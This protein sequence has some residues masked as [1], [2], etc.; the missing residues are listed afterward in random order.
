MN[1][2]IIDYIVG[3]V[4]NFQ[5]AFMLLPFFT[6]LIYHEREFSSF[7]IA[8]AVCLVIGIPLT[9]KKPKNKVFYTKDGCVAVALSWVAL[10]VFGALPFVVS[11]YIPHPVDA[12][13]ET[14]SGFTTTGSSILTD[15]EVLPH[16]VL[17]WRSFTHWIGGMGVLVF[18]LSLLPLT[19]GYHMNLMKAESP[20]PSVSKLVPKVQSTAKIL[21]T[22][23]F[24]MTLAQIVLLL[25]GKVPLFDTLCITFGTAGTGGFGI[26]NDSIGSYSTYCQ[27]VTTIFMILFGVNFS[28]YYLILTKKF[29]Q[30]FKYEEVR[31]YFGIIIASILIITFNTVHLFRNVLVAFQQVAFQVA[32]IIT[33]TG[34]SSTDFN[35]WPA[36]SKTVLV[37]LMFV[38][39]CAGST[40]G[41][42]KV[43]R[44]LILCKAAKK[45]FQLYLHPNAIK[46]IKMDNKIISHEILRSTNIYISVYLLIFAASVLL[47]AIDNFDLITNFTAV[48][49]TL[50]NIGPG[51]EIAGPMGNFSS[52]SYLSK[53]VLIFDMLAGRLEIFPLLLLFFKDTWK[54]F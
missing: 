28:V 39:A 1:F 47:I 20:G 6:A 54:R 16:C 11:G 44:I 29:R 14:V 33:T 42:I 37:L 46:K 17:I 5:A 41:G 15:V 23:Y 53:S 10:C 35:Q 9:L 8:M 4:C 24:G 27:V 38:G 18:L 43:S 50:N 34:F 26:V 2:R 31:Y 25:I 49:A 7:L 19:G 13:F 40:G 22:I 45:E 12:L 21:Y 30:A 52:F 48:A 32:S 36:L 3:W 51:F